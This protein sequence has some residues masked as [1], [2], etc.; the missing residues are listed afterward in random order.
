MGFT[1]VLGQK[2]YS[3]TITFQ[4]NSS[5]NSIY[6]LV[7]KSA[8]DSSVFASKG[9]IKKIKSSSIIEGIWEY[10][11]AKRRIEFTNGSFIYQT[12]LVF[13]K[14][15]QI[16]YQITGFKGFMASLTSGGNEEWIFKKLDGNKT[17]IKWTFQ[18]YRK[19]I[20]TA[21]VLRGFV[22]DDIK[23][24]MQQSIKLIQSKFNTKSD[25]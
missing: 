9:L 10:K 8:I 12:I 13:N 11:N 19:N 16:K 7:A 4:V 14:N 22:K 21:L 25:E 2:A 17:E 18:L 20:F 3:H 15:E 1:K 5:I 6:E 23:P 24:M